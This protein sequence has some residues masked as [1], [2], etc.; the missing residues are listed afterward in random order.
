[1]KIVVNTRLLLKN[2]MDGVGYFAYYTLKKITEAH[3]EHEFYFLFDRK[4]DESFIFGKNVTPIVI[5]PQ[6]RHPFLWYIWFEYSVKRVLKRIKPDVFFSPEGY[7]TLNTNIKSI[8]V[9]HDLAFEYHPEWVPNLVYRYYTYFSPKFANKA[10]LICTVSN[11]SKDDIIKRYKINPDKIRVV[12]NGYNKTL[13]TV[14]ESDKERIRKE[15]AFGSNYFIFVGGLNPRKNITG[16]IR[17]FEQ[18]KKNTESM[19]KLLIIGKPGYQ[20]EELRA[21]K[22]ASAYKQDIVFMGRVNSLEQLNNIAASSEAVVYV[23]FFEGFGIPCLEAMKWET[24]LI[25]SNTSSMPEVC[26]DAALY[27]D[28]YSID[29]I[30]DALKQ[31]A[32]DA[33][34]RKSLIEKGKVQR[35]KFSWDKTAALLWE[36]IEEVA[37]KK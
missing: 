35:D 27:V 13:H 31:I 1:M 16:L 5:G 17:A 15:Y 7:L 33:E 18:F 2:K 11:F 8:L 37:N 20:A 26:G 21:L 23:P 3:P 28:P 4:Y 29:S 19:Y 34:L 12:Y 36:C 14:N 22:E 10:N 32:S 25:T 24:A 6:A 9:M 30:A